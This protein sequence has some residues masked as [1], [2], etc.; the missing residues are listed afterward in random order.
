MEKLSITAI[1]KKIQQGKH[2]HAVADDYSFTIKIDEYVPYIC[3]AI[4]DGHQFRK[5]LWNKC[6]HTEYERWFE[7]D[8][9]TFT[10]IESHPITI[11]GNDSRF[12]YDLNRSP[13]SAI[14]DDAWGK[15]LWKTSL[16]EQEKALS[17]SKHTNFYKV[18]YA[19]VVKIEEIHSFVTIFDMHSY[20]WRRWDR[21]VPTFNIGTKNVDMKR[22]GTIVETWRNALESI[23][24][25]NGIKNNAKINDVFQGNGYL[26]KFVA[27]KF[28]NTL[29]L[30]T[31]IKKI[32]CDELTAIIYPEVV[33]AIARALKKKIPENIE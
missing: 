8:P 30:A 29:V 18:I 28:E 22:F 2:F 25:P 20:N 1:I 10:L 17:L 21:E 12:E 7:E 6:L 9:E 14:Y 26:L 4:H 33:D 5:T 32:Y 19:L 27:E 3:T 23:V 15:Q 31:E 16:S 13:E 11:K 24:L